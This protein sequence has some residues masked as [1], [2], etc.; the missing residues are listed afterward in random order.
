MIAMI[1][2]KKTACVLLISE[3]WMQYNWYRWNASWWNTISENLKFFLPLSNSKLS[4]TW[5]TRPCSSPKHISANNVLTRE[6]SLHTLSPES[7]QGP[8]PPGLCF[9]MLLYGNGKVNHIRMQFFVCLST[10][11]K[12]NR[13]FWCLHNYLKIVFKNKIEYI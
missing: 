9:F 6:T 1:K 4:K 2:K 10:E 8:N 12:W 11:E 7:I 5:Y 3:L 13:L